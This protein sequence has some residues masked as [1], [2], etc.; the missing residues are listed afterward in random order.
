MGCMG[1]RVSL[2]AKISTNVLIFQVVGGAV[3][4][5]GMGALGAGGWS[6]ALHR[7]RHVPITHP[8]QPH[9]QSLGRML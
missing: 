3:R 6:Q 2:V 1:L 4:G 7:F 9:C 8:A 5:V